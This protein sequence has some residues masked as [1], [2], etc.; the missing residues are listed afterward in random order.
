MN[1][2]TIARSNFSSLDIHVLF[3][4]R[5]DLEIFVRYLTSSRDCEF[6]RQIEDDIGFSDVPAFG[7]LWRRGH[8][9]RIALLRTLV[10]PAHD[11][12]NILLREPAI[13][14][15]CSVVWIGVPGRHHTGRYFLLDRLRPRSRIL[16]AQQRHRRYFARPMTR[17]T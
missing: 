15:E 12:I 1:Y 14:L 8:V 7:E 4:I 5:R 11:R 17:N 9:F 13:I 16:V 3:E 2:A 10:D 6:L